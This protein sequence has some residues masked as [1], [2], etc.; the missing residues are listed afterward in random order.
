MDDL[1]DDIIF[2]FQQGDRNAF[3]AIYWH[4]RRPIITFC[5]CMVPIED[6]EDITADVFVTLWKLRAQ[7]DSIRNIKAFLYVTARNACFNYL[8]HQKTKSDK[9]KELAFMAEREQEL[10]LQSEIESE[11]ITL[12]KREID[13]LPQTCKTVFSMSFLEGY[14]NAAI[15]QKLGISDQTVRNLK[16]IALKTIKKNLAGKGLQLSA[17]MLLVDRLIRE[18]VNVSTY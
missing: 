17:V 12:I 2:S 11:L 4:L 14:E 8:K 10:I 9:Q 5:K 3:N 1:Q 7:W 18:L 6:A 13:G 16:S 15:A